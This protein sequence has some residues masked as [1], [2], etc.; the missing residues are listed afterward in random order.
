MKTYRVDKEG[1]YVEERELIKRTESMV[2]FMAPKL[3]PNGVVAAVSVS[4]RIE[5][6]GHRHFERRVEAYDFAMH[7]IVARTTSLDDQ[8]KALWKQKGELQD[9]YEK[10]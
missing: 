2:T 6:K 3:Q 7:L 9:D 10:G 1:L 5:T 8:I 4:E